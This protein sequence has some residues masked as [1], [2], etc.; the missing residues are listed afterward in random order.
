[1]SIAG[2]Q[3]RKE[4]VDFAPPNAAV[5][6]SVAPSGQPEAVPVARAALEEPPMQG[7]QTWVSAQAKVSE[8]LPVSKMDVDEAPRGAEDPGLGTSLKSEEGERNDEGGSR[9]SSS[10]PKQTISLVVFGFSLHLAFV[11]ATE[12]LIYLLWSSCS[13]FYRPSFYLCI[14]YVYSTA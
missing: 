10:W 9:L 7:A 4:D 12:A 8:T 1:V 11:G 14:G 3:P 5:R 6:S 13:A 2:S